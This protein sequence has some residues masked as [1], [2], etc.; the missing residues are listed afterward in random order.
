MDACCTASHGVPS[1]AMNDRTSQLLSITGVHKGYRRGEVWVPVLAD[2]SLEVLPGEVVAVVGGRLAG[3]TTLLK[4]AAGVE[5]PDD[6]TVLLGGRPLAELADRPREVRWADR[7]GPGL[8]VEVAEFVGWPVAPGGRGR[9]QAEREAAQMLD[10]VGA[11]ECLRRRWGELSNWQRLLVGLARGFIGAPRLVV[12]D[13]LLDAL[14]EPATEQASNLVRSLM[15][16]S[17]PRC[18]VLMSASELESAMFAD[19][20][21]TITGKGSLRVMSGRL[22][23]AGEVI[24]FRACA[25]G[26]R[27]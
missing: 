4:L 27:D 8:E 18:G 15:D 20:V 5:R 6:G 21:L 25:Q 24:P 13:D 26:D 3:K 14:G 9:R 2:V 1:G 10:R 11:R 17:Q 19:R 12:V 22:T 16:S 7:N 23:D